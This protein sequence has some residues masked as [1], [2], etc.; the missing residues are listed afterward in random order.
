MR[1]NNGPNK[2]PEYREKQT[3]EAWQVIEGFLTRA[4]KG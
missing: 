3:R 2:N 4:L 1:E